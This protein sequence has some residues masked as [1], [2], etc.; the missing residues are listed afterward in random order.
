MASFEQRLRAD[1]LK[2]LY[3]YWQSLRRDRRA[4]S[5][6]DIDPSEIAGILSHIGLVDV[7][8]EPSR[9]RI[10]LLGARIVDWYG[11]DVTG[12]YLDEIDFGVAGGS[13]FKILDQAVDRA[14]PAH[15]SGAY[16]KQDGRAIRYERLYLPLSNDARRVDMLIGATAILPD[17]APILGDCLDT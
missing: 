11:C 15:M 14:V 13:T 6:A 4:P 7:E 5:R 16:T 9:Y 1:A 8:R 10:R 3:T 17:R 12:R 2:V